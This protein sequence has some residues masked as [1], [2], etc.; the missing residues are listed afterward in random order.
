MLASKCGMTGVQTGASASST[1]ARR[2]CGAPATTAL[3]RLRTD[4][5]DLYYLHRWDKTRADRG[6]RRRAG[7]TGG[8]RAR[9]ARSG[10]PRSRPRRCAART[11]C[12]R[13][14]PCRASTR[15]G[16]AIPRSRC[17]TS[18]AATRRRAGRLLL[19]WP[20]AFSPAASPI[21]RRSTPKD[22][23]R[24]MPRF[25]EPHFAR[26]PEAARR[27]T[28]GSRSRPAARR[29]SSRWP[30][31]CARHRTWCRFPAPRSITHLEEN[32]GAA[33]VHLDDELLA[34]IEALINPATVSGAR[35]NAATQSE[36]DTE[37]L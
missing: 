18:A 10:C 2:R 15:C 27:R 12:T 5:I 1:A 25:A 14:P 21:R 29:R 9:S 37:E 22:I 3:A 28:N 33:L 11:R 36:I 20:A 17:S 8:A 32:L 4:V 35:Y 16:R 24:D 23:R 34:R 31:C 6:Q 7:R 13:S 30:G 19:R 26:Q